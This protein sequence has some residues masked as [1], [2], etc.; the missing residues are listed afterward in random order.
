MKFLHGLA[1][2]IIVFNIFMSN[3]MGA[4]ISGV[5][6]YYFGP[7]TSEASAC[8]AA[9]E[10]AKLDSLRKFYGESI[11]FDQNLSCRESRLSDSDD[12]QLNK[13]I[14]SQI[15]GDIKSTS[16]IK[17]DVLVT[18][19]SKICRVES[20]SDIVVSRGK[21]DPNFDIGVHINQSVFRPGEKLIINIE[22]SVPMHVAIFNLIPYLSQDKQI[23]RLFPNEKDSVSL[24]TKKRAI[25]SEGYSYE[26]VLPE[27][28]PLNRSFVDEYLLIVVTKDP[29]KWLEK[30]SLADLKARLAELP[31]DRIRYVKRGYQLLIPKQSNN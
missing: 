19:G 9:E 4:W 8:M 10:T 14:W 18:A 16:L 5:G 22:P 2:S 23:F 31:M 17:K 6:E 7:E 30:Y 25:P 20:V 15:G 21:S 12:C 1:T 26:I 24:I 27:K 29:I 13:I 3:A 11:S 28:A